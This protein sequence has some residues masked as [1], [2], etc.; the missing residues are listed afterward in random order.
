MKSYILQD[1]IEK[2]KEIIRHKVKFIFE[3]T[4]ND[5]YKVLDTMFFGFFYKSV[6]EIFAKSHIKKRTMD[7][8]DYF[9]DNFKNMDAEE[10]YMSGYSQTVAK[11]FDK[12]KPGFRKIEE[13]S[14]ELLNC[15]R[16]CIDKLLESEDSESMEELIKKSFKKDEAEKQVEDIFSTLDNIVDIIKKEPSLIKAPFIKNEI[17]LI[18]NS[19]YKGSKQRLREIVCNS[20]RT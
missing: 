19:T 9:L 10:L 5:A 20:Y 18:L 17:I 13:N 16:H 4:I 12:Y 1:S 7:F 15:T 3:E 8:I 14:K 11:Y 2:H 6:F